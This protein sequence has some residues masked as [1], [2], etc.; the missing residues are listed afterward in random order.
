MEEKI[1]C[2]E[3]RQFNRDVEKEFCQ[4]HNHGKGCTKLKECWGTEE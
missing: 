3:D 2:P 1:V 4:S